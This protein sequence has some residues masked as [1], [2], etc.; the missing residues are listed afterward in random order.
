MII[1]ELIEIQGSSQRL[2]ST[3]ERYFN[4]LII[5]IMNSVEQP[6]ENK[7][8]NSAEVDIRELSFEQL[9]KAREI[10]KKS[11]QRTERG[12]MMVSGKELYFED[13]GGYSLMNYSSIDGLEHYMVTH[14]N[15]I[16]NDSANKGMDIETVI[17]E[18]ERVL[19][20]E[21]RYRIMK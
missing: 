12:F 13:M 17:Q 1:D 11:L 16:L 9:Q 6:T 21:F 18:L 20:E 19:S 8:E 4:K 15:S 5:K 3:S 14:N 10:G 2:E 7:A